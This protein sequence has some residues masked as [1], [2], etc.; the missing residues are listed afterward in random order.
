MAY[1]SKQDKAELAPAIKAVLNKYNMKGTISVR[2]HSTLVVTLQSGAIDFKDYS[3]GAGYIQVN[4][5]WIDDHY[6]TNTIARDFLN[7]LLA[8]M[9][10]TKYYNNDDA[11]VDYFDRSHYTDINVGKW[12]KPYF[13]QAKKTKVAKKTPKKVLD[14]SI[15]DS[16]EAIARMTL[17]EREKFVSDIVGT[18]P[19]L[20]DQLMTSI[21]YQLMESELDA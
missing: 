15:S 21:G 1:V 13:V 2:N 12:N 17:T 6:H 3:H 19:T 20:A 10:G 5:Y 7:E 4:V 11:M 14:T 8:A 18:Y 16:A 9:K